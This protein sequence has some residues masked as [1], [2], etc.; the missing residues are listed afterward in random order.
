MINITDYMDENGHEFLAV[1]VDKVSGLKAVLAVH[2]STL[3]PGLGPPCMRTFESEQEAIE[4]ALVF[5]HG[6]TYKY[7]V[8]GIPFGGGRMV[9]MEVP[10]DT[11]RETVVRALG[12]C[13]ESLGGRYI[14]TGG[15]IGFSDAD[16]RLLKDETQYIIGLPAEMG[17]SGE[18]AVMA[19]YGIYWG[20]KACAQEVF[21]TDALNGKVVA[22][23]GFGKVGSALA[24]NIKQENVDLIVADIRP[25]AAELAR[26]E[27]G[28][29]I[30][31]PDDIYD[32]ACD[33]FSPCAWGWVLKDETISRLQCK[34]V[35]GSANNQLVEPQR[36]SRELA[37][38]GI[39]YAP[40]FVINAGGFINIASEVGGY[41]A[42]AARAR[43][44]GIQQ[45]LQQVFAFAREKKITPTEAAE[46]FA[47][48]RLQ[49]DPHD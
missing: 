11:Q 37:A 3:G 41:D 49:S 31:S 48:Q 44:R 39:L 14:I 9:V 30:V 47:R 29:Q 23:Q 26:R 43:I 32:V 21:N 1:F 38:R 8:A 28:A 42:E 20:M 22:I 34:I 27:F 10:D 45:T 40:D 25:Q 4:H 13:V 15:G 17:G 18:P 19:G 35:A 5:S 46:V 33:I 24:E 12:R 6:Q 2:D 7:A 36:H 16:T